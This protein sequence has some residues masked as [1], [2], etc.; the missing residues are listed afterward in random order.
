MGKRLGM[1]I[2]AAFTAAACAAFESPREG[3]G[4][5]YPQ[6]RKVEQMDDYHGTKVADPYRWLEDLDSEETAAWVKAQNQVTF[7]Y[8]EHIPE[9]EQITR[10]LTELWNYA[11]YGTPWKVADRYFFLKNDGLQNQSVLYVADSLDDEPRELLDANKLSKDGTTAV[12]TIEVNDDASL[13]V[14][15]TSDAGSD[16]VEYRVRD[17]ATGQDLDDVLKWV[18]FSGAAWDGDGD[19]FYYSRYDAPEEG[20]NALET[21][22]Y[23]HKLYYHKIGTPQSDDVLVYDRPDQK[24]W[25]FGGTVTDDGAYLVINIWQGTEKKNRIYLK[26]LRKDDA[27]IVPLLDKFDASYSFIDNDKNT[28]Y[29]QTDNNAPRGRVI[30]INVHHPEPENWKEIVPQAAETIEQVDLINDRFVAIYLKDAR[31]AVRTYAMTG[32]DE[33]EIELPGIGAAAGFT[34]KRSNT[35][36]FYSFATF[37]APPTIYRYDFATGSSQLYRRPDVAYDPDQ[38]ETKQVFYTSKDGTRI[39]MFVTTKKGVALDGRNPTLLYG[40][41][42]FDIPVTP[43]FSSANIVWMEMG[44]IYAVANIRGGGEYGKE[45]H[46]AGRLKNKQNVFDDFIAAAEWLIKNKYTVPAKLA[47]HGRSNGGLLVGACMTQRPDLFGAAIP[48]VGV[49]DMLRFH[50]FTIGWAW[51]SDYGSSENADE[52]RVQYAYSPLHNIK[53]GTRYPST[54]I[55]TGDHDDRVV[56]SHSFKF[57]AALQ[58][59]HAGKNPVLIRIETDAGHGAGKPTSKQ[60]EESA[61]ILAFLVHELDVDMKSSTSGHAMMSSD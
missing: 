8:L 33:Q 43:R 30:A 29:F 6:T 39:P 32:G 47:I 21:A 26:D 36:T 2:I 23:F 52:F 14:Y 50:K 51:V 18:K 13:M 20:T 46:D 45:W 19:G 57:A 49:L 60:I 9:R 16:W 15:G 28:F 11:K 25:G 58:E 61:D 34:G 40:Y 44:G 12:G 56:P 3:A 48:G 53:K 4:F 27:P 35:E 38:F 1:M 37:T 42:G 17:V 54:L 7:G 22:N 59:A 31:S 24:E 10:R 5:D 55:V 41:G